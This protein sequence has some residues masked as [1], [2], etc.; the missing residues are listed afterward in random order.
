MGQSWVETETAG[1]DLGD[2]RL[3]RR[4][5]TM[6]EAL[7]ERPGKS[8][9]TAFQD[10]SNTKAAYRFFSNGNVSIRRTRSQPLNLLSIARLKRA[11]SRWLLAISRRTRIAQTCFGRRG[12]FCP[13]IRPLFHAGR[14]VR[15]AG[16]LATGMMDPPSTPANLSAD[17][18]PA[19][20]TNL[21]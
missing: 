8:L 11:R 19:T 12:R 5:G 18:V 10:W 21:R 7:G 2:G 17:S 13:T 3:N 4:L 9:P 6:L 15:T 20:H 14:H 16:R 1:C